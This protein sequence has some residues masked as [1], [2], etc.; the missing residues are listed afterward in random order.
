MSRLSASAPA[1]AGATGG[2]STSKDDDHAEAHSAKAD[3]AR[4]AKADEKPEPAAAPPTALGQVAIRLEGAPAG[5]TVKI[6]GVPVEP[7]LRLPRSEVEVTLTVHAPG[8]RSFWQKVVP[9]QDRTI[10]VKMYR[11]GKGGKGDKDGKPMA[12]NPW[13]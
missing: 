1:N 2:S 9:D 5:A 11:R 10:D 8:Y 13:Q 3:E 7:P 4:S 12:K 6:N